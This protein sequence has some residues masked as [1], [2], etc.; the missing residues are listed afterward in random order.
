MEPTH[1]LLTTGEVADYLRVSKCT[2]YRMLEEG[3]LRAV[4]TAPRSQLLFSRT[5]LLEKLEALAGAGQEIPGEPREAPAAAG[6]GSSSSRGRTV[7]ARRR[8]RKCR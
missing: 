6:R 1:E 2:V 5:A 8:K 4:R 3:R 7:E